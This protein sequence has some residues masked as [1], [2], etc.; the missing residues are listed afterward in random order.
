MRL[1]I[2]REESMKK[3]EK[4]S[5]LCDP[6]EIYH[7]F[8]HKIVGIKV[9]LIHILKLKKQQLMFVH[10]INLLSYYYKVLL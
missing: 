6:E 5:R 2:I 10:K 8:K 1:Q 4:Q 3:L 9:V 7:V